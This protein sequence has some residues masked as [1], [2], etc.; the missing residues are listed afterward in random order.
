M[1]DSL[2]PSMP[3]ST[4]AD[5]EAAYTILRGEPGAGIVLVCDH[6]SNTLPVGYGTLGLSG[7]ELQR[8][9][10]YDI[11]AAELVRHLSR[12]LGSPAVL[13]AFS[14]LLIDCNR[15]LNDPTLIMRISDGSIVPGNRHI[16]GAERDHRIR[17]YYEPYH[18]ALDRVIDEA[19]AV[20]IVPMLVSVHSF[21]PV[22]RGLPRPWHVSVLWDKDPRLPVR[23]IEALR[24]ERDLV[25][26]DNEPYSGGLEGDC[27]WR[28]GTMRGLAHAIIEIRQDLIASSS[29][30]HI[31][32][33][34]LARIL[35]AVLASP[36]AKDDLMRINHYGS[37]V[38]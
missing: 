29:G 23:M 38:S 28:H 12:A 37:N 33:E 10:A 32:G 4:K 6:A 3:Q 14:R 15:G 25:V 11:G 2:G 17:T 20:G 22:W 21:T 24:A 1:Q 13:S 8:H 5:R 18:D 31:W 9:I 30:A 16:D 27:M 35:Q 19:L 34:R 26:G 36:G 7:S